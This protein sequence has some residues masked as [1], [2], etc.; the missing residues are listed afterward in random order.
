MGEG[1]GV[2]G[3]GSAGY[4]GQVEEGEGA[5]RWTHR[6]GGQVVQSLGLDT[7]VAQH[8]RV[9]LQDVGVE[10]VSDEALVDSG[11]AYWGGGGVHIHAFQRG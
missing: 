6:G 11:M 3:T 5:V 1:G 2:V 8:Q 9:H 7:S 10:G 4:G